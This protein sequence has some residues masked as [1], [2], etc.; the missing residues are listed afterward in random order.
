MVRPVR[1]TYGDDAVAAVGGAVLPGDGCGGRKEGESEHGEREEAGEHLV[2]LSAW[3][4]RLFGLFAREPLP[5]SMHLLYPLD[6]LT[7]T[8]DMSKRRTICW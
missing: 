5:L 4:Q 7:E 1:E 6:G 3:L 2:C 8:T